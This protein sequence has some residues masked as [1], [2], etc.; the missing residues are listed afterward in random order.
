MQEAE[1]LPEKM[2]PESIPAATP[3]KASGKNNAKPKSV[4]KIAPKKSP[5]TPVTCKK[6]AGNDAPSPSPAKRTPKRRRSEAEKLMD[7]HVPS[8]RHAKPSKNSPLSADAEKQTATT[9]VQA[10][11][12]ARSQ[13]PA[14]KSQKPK[15]ARDKQSGPEADAT[16]SQPS[17]PT[18]KPSDKEGKTLA[19]HLEHA[20]SAQAESPSKSAPAKR[21]LPLTTDVPLPDQS[22]ENG[23]LASS[24]PQH[25]QC[26]NTGMT[27][28]QC[29]RKDSIENILAAPLEPSASANCS[30]KKRKLQELQVEHCTDMP[31]AKKQHIVEHDADIP[32]SS[33]N[34]DQTRQK[35][36]FSG[37]Q[38]SHHESQ[39]LR[40]PVANSAHT[41]DQSTI[42]PNKTQKKDGN[43]LH[44]KV[45][46]AGVP[47]SSS[48]ADCVSEIPD[49]SEDVSG[50]GD[51]HS[52]GPTVIN[53]MLTEMKLDSSR[54]K[55]KGSNSSQLTATSR[56]SPQRSNA[57]GRV[58]QK[59]R[60]KSKFSHQV[61]AT[62]DQ[63]SNPIKLSI[64]ASNDPKTVQPKSGTTVKPISVESQELDSR[65]V[66][67]NRHAAKDPHA[68]VSTKDGQTQPFARCQ[69]ANNLQPNGSIKG[70][71]KM[72]EAQKI[73]LNGRQSDSRGPS[74]P[75]RTLPAR[76]QSAR[77]ISLDVVIDKRFSPPASASP[78]PREETCQPADLVVQTKK[79][80]ED[81]VNVFK[82]FRSKA[83]HS[84]S[85]SPANLSEQTKSRSPTPCAQAGLLRLGSANVATTVSLPKS[86]INDSLQEPAL[87]KPIACNLV[88]DTSGLCQKAHPDYYSGQK[89]SGPAYKA[90]NANSRI[91]PVK[92][93][94]QQGGA[95]IQVCNSIDTEG[96][97][98]RLEPVEVSRPVE[99]S[100]ASLTMPE[101]IVRPS[102][103][104]G[105]DNSDP[106][107]APLS[108]ALKP[109][110]AQ[111]AK[112]TTLKNSP[113]EVGQTIP[114]Q[115]V[116]LLSPASKQ[117]AKPAPVCK[118]ATNQ[119]AQTMKSSVQK[120]ASP[121]KAAKKPAP[122]PQNP[123]TSPRERPQKRKAAE[124]V[125]VYCFC[126]RFC[127]HSLSQ[128]VVS[129][130]SRSTLKLIKLPLASIL[131]RY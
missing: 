22:L 123:K 76:Q 120:P 93:V 88:Q 92:L 50:A 67:G 41:M 94:L 129:L 40:Q 131:P 128:D 13:S 34:S 107:K 38:E 17:S 24:L 8:K 121:A 110:K 36:S 98:S 130:F 127:M 6:N 45:F 115:R 1:A 87:A 106:I 30:A 73:S 31:P 53:H 62:T 44:H 7:D 47:V 27:V 35:A 82:H 10:P 77:P 64:M 75:I 104:P 65:T 18:V 83:F 122:K 63:S 33:P 66:D 118:K 19:N 56:P 37:P 12:T 103:E 108:K 95:N 124:M 79:P 20:N 21:E 74:L 125:R 4:I 105:I 29:P 3:A 59:S 43:Q 70:T 15:T 116:H 23:S 26:P 90:L 96:G 52:E 16:P 89:L 97:A 109:G 91:S 68:S 48:S 42:P 49:S 54:L 9:K 80:K 119:A 25:E 69:N 61:L 51:K 84:R 114:T 113:Q 32:L 55:S 78:S 101:Q 117:K 72:C 112:G 81:L 46:G 99:T 60:N 71:E 102:S 2:I 86:G 58:S 14:D 111:V 126:V 5:K 11:C 85:Q 57:S 28:Q 39:N 100:N